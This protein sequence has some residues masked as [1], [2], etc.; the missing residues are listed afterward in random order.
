MLRLFIKDVLD[1][2]LG[3]VFFL[4]CVVSMP[5]WLP[6]TIICRGISEYYRSL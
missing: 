4:L 6:A 3:A 5:I 1:F 2:V